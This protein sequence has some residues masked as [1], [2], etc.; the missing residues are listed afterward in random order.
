MYDA[1][2]TMERDTLCCPASINIFRFMEG[3][4]LTSAFYGGASLKK[5]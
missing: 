3:G 2:Q 4:G 1:A 5:Y